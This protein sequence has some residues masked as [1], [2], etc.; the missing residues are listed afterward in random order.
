MK[1]IM[2]LSLIIIHL[3]NSRCVLVI[4]VIDVTT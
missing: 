4:G 2:I 3:F 1:Y